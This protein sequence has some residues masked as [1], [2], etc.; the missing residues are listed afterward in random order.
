MLRKL[1]IG[2]IKHMIYL[3]STL[4]EDLNIENPTFVEELFSTFDWKTI[5]Q[6]VISTSVRIL[7][8][9]LVFFI[10]N[11]IAKWAIEEGL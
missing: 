5:A 6:Q 9:L 1:L 2:V 7:F 11:L 3:A 8:T 4:E 10:I